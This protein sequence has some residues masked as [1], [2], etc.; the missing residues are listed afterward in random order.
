M[1]IELDTKK[2]RPAAEE[3]FPAAGLFF[4]P[5]NEPIGKKRHALPPWGFS[6]LFTV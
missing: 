4:N 5:V 3:S 6:S 2:Y 1:H